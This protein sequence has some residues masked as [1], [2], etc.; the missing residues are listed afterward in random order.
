MYNQVVN[1]WP[2]RHLTKTKFFE[3]LEFV[4]NGGYSLKHYE[5][6]SKI[7]LN[8]D[9]L[10]AIKNKS[11]QNRYRLNVGTIVE[12]YMLKVKLGNRT[13]GQVE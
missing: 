11:I 8:K 7:G 4:K 1:A 10:Y 2:Y 9:K 13:L 12:S 6:Y 3:V 5:Q